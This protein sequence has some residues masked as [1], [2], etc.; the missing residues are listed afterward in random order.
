MRPGK[1]RE[2]DGNSKHRTFQGNRLPLNGRGCLGGRSTQ[3]C[4]ESSK[5]GKAQ[6]TKKKEKQRSPRNQYKALNYSQNIKPKGTV[7]GFSGAKRE[8]PGVPKLATRPNQRAGREKELSTLKSSRR[9]LR[10]GAGHRE[11]RT[12][13][14]FKRRNDEVRWDI[15]SNKKNLA[16]PVVSV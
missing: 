3:Y 11:I 12:G 15:P 7:Q 5:A 13:G 2:W 1:G 4:R 16:R 8:S 10:R 14:Y 6:K 9:F